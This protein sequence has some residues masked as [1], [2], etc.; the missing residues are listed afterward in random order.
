MNEKITMRSAI[1]LHLRGIREL[2]KVSHKFFPIVTLECIF[3]AITPYITVFFSAQILKELATLRRE[4]VLWQWVIAGMVCVGIASLGKALLQRR[5]NTL[6]ND[7]YGRKEIL[8]IH[9]MFALDFSE[10]DKQENHDLRAQIRQN[11]NWAGWGLMRVPDTFESFLTNG[12]G[13]VSGMTLTVSLFTS[14]VPESAGRLTVLNHP[15]FILILAALMVGISML[16]G[17]LV[18]EAYR[19]SSD[20]AEEATFGNRLYD[21]F[22]FIGRDTKRSIDIRMNRQQDLVA[23]YWNSES[24]FGADGP[25]GKVT[26]GKLGIYASLGVCITTL[27]TGSIYVFTCLKAWGGAFDVGSVTQYVGAASAMVGNIFAL[28]GLT[29]TLK[30][31][32][33]YL[34]KTFAFLDIPNAMYQGSLTTEKRS[35]RKFDIEFRNVSFRYPGSD[36]WALRNVNMKFRVGKRLAIVG[37]NGS[38]KT[39]FIKL[40]C[41]L[42]DPQEGQILLNGIDIRKYR[43]DDYMNIFSVVFQDF[44]LICQPLGANVAGSMHY[45]KAGVEQALRDAGFGDRLAAMEKGLDTMIYKNLSEDGVDVSGG[46][47]QKIAIARALYKDAPF[48]ILDEPT[49]ALDPVAEA[50]IYAKFDKIAG[51]KTAIYISHR[52]SSCKFC[53]EIAVFSGGAVIQQGTHDALVADEGG[54]YYELWHAQAQYYTAQS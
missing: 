12:I 29:G 30:A 10:L 42:Y 54:K 19:C 41:R 35:D 15:V 3:C 17:K 21:H 7:L 8:F 33:D 45:E 51:N 2:H 20:Y 37:E 52:L 49:A 6:L 40:L 13:I 26:Q 39:T 5:S 28:T 46:E 27:I 48:I 36:I 18:A 43:Y 25:I 23:A 34:E 31:N 1:T 32:S 38:G 4:A 24:P 14:V 16:A 11:E 9:K 50:E 22:G 44:Q 47:A 53:D